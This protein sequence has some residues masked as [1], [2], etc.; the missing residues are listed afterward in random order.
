MIREHF[1]SKHRDCKI[2]GWLLS[3]NPFSDDFK[4]I[5]SLQDSQMNRFD[6]TC[7]IFFLYKK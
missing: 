7:Q 1:L 5:Y 6:Y 2:L 4:K 3:L